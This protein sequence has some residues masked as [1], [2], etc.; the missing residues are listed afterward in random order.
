MVL[1]KY[2]ET[3][4]NRTTQSCLKSRS[5]IPLQRCDKNGFVHDTFMV[6]I[7]AHIK[8]LLVE[9]ELSKHFKRPVR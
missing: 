3:Q 7:I 4:T 6:Y 9:V 5:N 8:A 2:A 1:D